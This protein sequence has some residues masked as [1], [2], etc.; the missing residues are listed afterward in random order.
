LRSVGD[1]TLQ[2]SGAALW[3]LTAEQW[4]GITK[5]IG[6]FWGSRIL[7][8]T[9]MAAVGLNTHPSV[10]KGVGAKPFL[11]GFV[12]ALVVGITGFLL[13]ATIGQFVRL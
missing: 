13:A 5:S 9:A 11:V 12:G 10:F 7:L 4:E 3:L 2:N 1:A 6:E 8:G